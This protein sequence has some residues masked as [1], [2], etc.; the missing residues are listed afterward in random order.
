MRKRVVGILLAVPLVLSACGSNSSTTATT[1]AS[2]T[3]QA[4][5]MGGAGEA[6][7]LSFITS[8]SIG[9]GGALSVSSIQ[10]INVQTCFAS[11]A[12]ASGTLV[13]TTGTNNVVTGTLSFQVVS[14]GSTLSL[15]G[16]ENGTTITG[17]WTLTGGTGCTGSGTFTM[18]QA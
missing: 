9:S 4:D 1:T 17:T 3:W 5:I 12:T 18:T 14:G 16:T 10:F 15:S 7:A 13:V 6:G 8:F 11:D 2:G